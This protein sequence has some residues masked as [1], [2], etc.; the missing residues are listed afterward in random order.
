MEL[1]DCTS[2]LL[3]KATNGVNT[4]FSTFVIDTS[5]KESKTIKFFEELYGYPPKFK[6]R[7]D[8]LDEL[9]EDSFNYSNF[10][11]LEHSIPFMD[12][13]NDV[14]LAKIPQEV[15]EGKYTFSDYL[16]GYS[17]KIRTS[18]FYKSLEYKDIQHSIQNVP[19]FII[20]NGYNEIITA[21]PTNNFD[22]ISN[23]IEESIYDFCGAFDSRFT[24][25]KKL[26]LFFMEK[27][28]ADM[29]MKEIAKVN[30]D[31]V[32]TS[33][34]SIHCVGLDY[35]YTLA[36]QYNP[37][38]DFR[39]IPDLNQVKTLLK[40]NIG[41]GKTIV[42]HDQQQLRFRRRPVNIFPFFGRFGRIFSPLSSFLS[43]QEYFKGVPIYIVQVRDKEAWY[44][45]IV[46]ENYFN[47]IGVADSIWGRFIQYFDDLVGFGNNWIMQ[48][49]LDTVSG[50]DV[51]NYVFFERDKAVKFC[52]N[53]E[54]KVCRYSG[55]RV[56]TFL[57]LEAVVRKPKIMIHNLEDFLELW[58]ETKLVKM[59]NPIE[60]NNLKSVY[61][62]K[63][64]YFI[65]S[66]NSETY[67][68][69]LNGKKLTIS[70]TYGKMKQGVN[71]RYKRLKSFFVIF[72]GLY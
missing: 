59:C 48:G 19:V 18:K 50:N 13:V 72:L 55:S 34:L 26:G 49:S 27:A 28:D 57:N 64:T 37:K 52:K 58:E 33:G 46:F 60:F 15:E 10:G 53:Y 45:D 6:V 71:L 12:I 40:N 47:L 3:L 21:N 69:F 70:E 68:E 39:F 24:R 44:R 62:A 35:A 38:I 22:L 2:T 1:K 25:N 51:T 23:K 7:W 30:V 8:A 65:S 56:S 63:H 14:R 41:N 5:T 4:S 36:R 32:K 54:K 43:N 9:K 29:Y 17:D 67:L 66:E 42:E 61:K 31:G 11:V 16:E 20:L